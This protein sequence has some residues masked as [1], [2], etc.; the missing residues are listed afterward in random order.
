M[1]KKYSFEKQVHLTD[2]VPVGEADN[3]PVLWCVVLVL[4]LDHQALAGK[5]VSLSLWNQKQISVYRAV[6]SDMTGCVK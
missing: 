2:D 6:C 5:V 4:V 1:V 3:H